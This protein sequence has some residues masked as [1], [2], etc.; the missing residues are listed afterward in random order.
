MKKLL[1]FLSVTAASVSSLFGQLP[2]GATAPDFTFQDLNGNTHNLYTYL[3]QGK[4]VAIEIS[5]TWCSPCWAY[6][7]SGAMDSLYNIHDAPGDQGWKVIFIEGDGNTTVDQLNGI[8]STRGDWVT[9]T[10]FPILNPSGIPLNDFSAGYD[11]YSFPTLYLICPN[12]KV[13]HETINKY[14][15]GYVSTWN[16]AATMQCGPAGLDNIADANPVTIFPNPATNQVD[17]YFS[18]NNSSEASLS[19]SDCIG[20]VIDI[21]QFGRLYPG[22]QKIRYD[23]GQY[24]PG[25]YFFTIADGNGRAVRKKVWIR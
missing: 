24:A 8:G 15:R 7:T 25:L 22:D 5:A 9:G 10:S 4:Y 20:R 14:P 12:R 19:V 21:R 1:L 6:H 18:L 3:D 11:A 23:L 16:Y 13:I 2:D 17:L